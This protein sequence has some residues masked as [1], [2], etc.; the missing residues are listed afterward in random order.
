M[1]QIALGGNCPV[2]HTLVACGGNFTD[3][4]LYGTCPVDGTIVAVVNYTNPNAVQPLPV[5][6][7]A[8]VTASVS[9]TQP[10]SVAD[11]ATAIATEVVTLG[12]DTSAVIG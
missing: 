9:S 8:D 11:A 4:T 7:D 12:G 10:S 5:Q 6:A 3:A 1:A 2:C